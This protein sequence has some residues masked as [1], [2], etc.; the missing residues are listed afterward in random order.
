MA[1]EVKF[2]NFPKTE[3]KQ[4][5]AK[6]PFNMTSAQSLDFKN[7]SNSLGGS[8]DDGT[9]TGTGGFNETSSGFK[10]KRTIG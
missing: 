9:N 8:S 10:S 5:P 3:M 1:Q 4:K 6:A 7:A 2:A